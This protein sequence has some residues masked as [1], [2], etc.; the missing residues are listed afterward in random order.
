MTFDLLLTNRTQQRDT[1]GGTRVGPEG[2][3]SEH[4]LRRRHL[5]T[6]G[7][8]EGAG[9]DEIAKAYRRLVSDVTPGPEADHSR[10]D[11]A[12]SMLDEVNAAYRWLRMSAVA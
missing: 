9:P 4:E 11:L 8:G 6:L 1:V 3:G 12:L 10:V 5:A 7:L 2:P